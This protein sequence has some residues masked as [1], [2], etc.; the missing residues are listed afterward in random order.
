MFMKTMA[1]GPCD[2]VEDWVTGGA[3]VARGRAWWMGHG[4]ECLCVSL[5]MTTRLGRVLMGVRKA[6]ADEMDFWAIRSGWEK[7]ECRAIWLR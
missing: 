3:T 6:M 4:E 1:V 2:E 7:N 5:G